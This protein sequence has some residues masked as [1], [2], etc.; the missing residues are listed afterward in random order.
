MKYYDTLIEAINAL[1]LKGFTQDF[2]VKED[3]IY[4][5]VL[6]MNYKPKEFEIVEKHRFEG[7]S[8]VDDNSILYAI[9][10]KSGV[11]GLLVDSYGIYSSVSKEMLDKLK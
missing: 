6:K 8:S 2:N 10:T 5:P 7:M 4:C 1:K 11:K 3:T 9:S